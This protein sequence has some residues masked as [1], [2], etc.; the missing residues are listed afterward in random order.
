[1]KRLAIGLLA[2]VLALGL[3]VVSPQRAEA[4]LF[5]CAPGQRSVCSTRSPMARRSAARAASNRGK[6]ALDALDV[7]YPDNVLVTWDF[8]LDATNIPFNSNC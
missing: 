1:M 6:V 8:W 3:L 7:R 2:S 4:T 5:G